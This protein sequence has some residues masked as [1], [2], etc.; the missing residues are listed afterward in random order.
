MLIE[1][2]IVLQKNKTTWKKKSRNPL[3]IPHG[4]IVRLTAEF[5]GDLSLRDR[6]WFSFVRCDAVLDGATGGLTSV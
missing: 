3:D 5:T 6:P 2:R 4:F 1:S